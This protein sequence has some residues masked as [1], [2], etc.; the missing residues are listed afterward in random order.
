MI[1]ML[2]ELDMSHCRVL[3]IGSICHEQSNIAISNTRHQYGTIL[4]TPKKQWSMSSH[5]LT[6]KK[7]ETKF[8]LNIKTIVSNI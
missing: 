4:F 6:S 1:F 5:N 7:F 2:G 3:S 8:G